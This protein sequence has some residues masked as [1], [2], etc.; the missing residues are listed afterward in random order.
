MALEHC[1]WRARVLVLLLSACKLCVGVAEMV[2]PGADTRA[3]M[4]KSTAAGNTADAELLRRALAEV[5][6]LRGDVSHLTAR[7]DATAAAAAV[8][9]E[10]VHF[11]EHRDC[12]GSSGEATRPSWTRLASTATCT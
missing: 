1:R 2:P 3:D 10:R 11:L 5:A 6:Q 7:V 9:A 12:T 4:R 8:L